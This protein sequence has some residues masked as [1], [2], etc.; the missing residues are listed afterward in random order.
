MGNTKKLYQ[1]DLFRFFAALNVVLFHY[2]FRG[3]KADNMSILRIPLLGEYFKY[4][5][6]GVYLFFIISGFVIILSIEHNN[7]L[8]F[9]KSGF[10]GF[11]QLIGFV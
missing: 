7:L 4:G 8:D 1:I 6:L 10:F 3:H 9:I 11:T 5:Y 2:T